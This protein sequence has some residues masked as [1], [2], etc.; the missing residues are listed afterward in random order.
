[1][2]QFRSASDVIENGNGFF[3]DACGKYEEHSPCELTLA[4]GYGS[5][6]DGERLT[7]DI[8]VDCANRIVENISK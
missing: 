8:C 4:F 3:C 5:K 1:M 2:P 6:F 7:M